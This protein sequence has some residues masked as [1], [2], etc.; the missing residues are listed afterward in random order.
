[1]GYS[2]SYSPPMMHGGGSAMTYTHYSGSASYAPTMVHGG[3][4][5]FAAPSYAGAHMGHP[6]PAYAG[7]RPAFIASPYAGQPLASHVAPYAAAPRAYAPPSYVRPA[8]HAA[9]AVPRPTAV[10]A[11]PGV[12]PQPFVHAVPPLMPAHVPQRSYA[13]MEAMVHSIARPSNFVTRQVPFASST[14]PVAMP[15]PVHMAAAEPTP[16]AVP[17]PPPSPV[18][19]SPS[20]PNANPG[21]GLSGPEFQSGLS[22]M[23]PPGSMILVR[24]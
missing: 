24:G 18:L 23:S 2:A 20:Q 7:A 6:L 9:Y 10:Y 3:P 13:P 21:S 19:P 11:W 1:M 4:T 5:M 16:V 12:A 8:H 17:M 22:H 14:L 15:V